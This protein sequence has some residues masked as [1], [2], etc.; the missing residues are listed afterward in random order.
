MYPDKTALHSMRCSCVRCS[1]PL[2]RPR[3]LISVRWPTVITSALICWIVIGIL[4]DLAGCT[5]AIGATLGM[6]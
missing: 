3:A 2:P 5:P 1:P 4:L 6:L